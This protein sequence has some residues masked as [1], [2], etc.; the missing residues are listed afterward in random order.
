METP[1]EYAG[2]RG[3][4]QTAQRELFLER[5]GY[6]ILEGDEA[7]PRGRIRLAGVVKIANVKTDAVRRGTL[8]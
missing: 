3:Y 1:A 4:G 5:S 6:A 2:R 8:R 7:I